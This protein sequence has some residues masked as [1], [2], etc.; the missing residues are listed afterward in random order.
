MGQRHVSPRRV[1]ASWTWLMGVDR[2]PVVLVPRE[3]RDVA[4][5][6]GSDF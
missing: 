5:E 1:R 6:G 2:C 4:V 3:S